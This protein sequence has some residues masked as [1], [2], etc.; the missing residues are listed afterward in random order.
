MLLALRQITEDPTAIENAVEHARTDAEFWLKLVQQLHGRPPQ[1]LD[2]R[3][4]QVDADEFGCLTYR[5]AFDDG[6]P[7][8]DVSAAAL[9]A[10]PEG[11]PQ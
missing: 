10:L 9:E 6:T 11:T 1:A 4:A 5:S 2:V 8:G 7:I 3:T